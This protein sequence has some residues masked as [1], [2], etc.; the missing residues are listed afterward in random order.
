[1]RS[2][3]LT[4]WSRIATV[5]MLFGL[6][7]GLVFGQETPASDKPKEEAPPAK[8]EEK[9]AD[10]KP[11]EAKPAEGEAKTEP[12]S[13]MRDVAPIFV[14]N[15]IACHN[16]KK[17]ESKYVMTTFTQLAKG[18][19]VG[20]GITLEPGKPDESYLFELLGPEGEPRMPFKQDPLPDDEIALLERW[21]TEGAKYDG[22]SPDEDWTFLLR[23]TQKVSHPRGL[24]VAV[25]ITAIAFSPTASTSRRRAIT[26]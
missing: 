3:T 11:A 12:V 14:R 9:P 19:K 15:C 13:F 5:L 24:S 7:A 26:N 2:P 16:P 4:R 23:K 25:P 18:G 8:A 17:P 10:P 1:M 22:A 21:M 20:D 6:P